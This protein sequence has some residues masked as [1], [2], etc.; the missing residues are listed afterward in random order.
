MENPDRLTQR[1]LDFLKNK[2]DISGAEIIRRQIE[3]GGKKNFT[4]LNEVFQEAL[5]DRRKLKEES[6]KK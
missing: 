2:Q 4:P 1:F 6:S 3:S 5:E